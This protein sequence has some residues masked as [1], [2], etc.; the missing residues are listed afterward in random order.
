VAVSPVLIGS[1]RRGLSVPAAPTLGEAWR[2][3]SRQFLLGNDVLYDFDLRS[4]AP[5][6]GLATPS[7]S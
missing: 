6:R 4:K 2:P 3:Q 5:V 1:G 7:P